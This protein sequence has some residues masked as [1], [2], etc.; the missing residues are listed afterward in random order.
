MPTSALRDRNNLEQPNWMLLSVICG[1]YVAATIGEQ[2]LGPIFP[3]ALSEFG[4]SE[5]DG[6]IAF[7]LLTASIAILNLIGGLTL[8]RVG[9]RR[10]IALAS[11]FSLLGAVIAATSHSFVQLA[12][13]QIF[14]RAGAGPRK[15]EWDRLG[16][17][18]D[19]GWRLACQ[20]YLSGDI[21]ISWDKD[22]APLNPNAVDKSLPSQVDQ[23]I[24]NHWLQSKD[25]D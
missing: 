11:L 18:L 5:L 9:A 6:G 8:A 15:R 17:L 19:Q 16:E 12:T 14:L 13:S 20:T 3:D 21:S 10:T 7:G 25:T 4:L 2:V 1:S 23:R 24:K 22:Q